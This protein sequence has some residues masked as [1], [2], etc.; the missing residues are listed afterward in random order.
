MTKNGT[1]SSHRHGLLAGL[2][3][4]VAA[5][6]TARAAPASAEG[7]YAINQK[8]SSVQRDAGD[9]SDL[10]NAYAGQHCGSPRGG[11]PQATPDGVGA[12]LGLYNVNTHQLTCAI[13]WTRGTGAHVVWGDVYDRF[14]RDGYERAYGYPIVD[15]T[16]EPPDSHISQIF[17]TLGRDG[18]AA[19]ERYTTMVSSTLGAYPLRGGF[20]DAW[21]GSRGQIGAPMG[22]AQPNVATHVCHPGLLRGCTSGE[23]GTTKFDGYQAFQRW[24]A[25]AQRH[26]VTCVC[27]AAGN[28]PTTVLA[29]F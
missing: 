10:S 21:W 22:D 2:L 4:L 5:T 9:A 11:T 19:P 23:Q 27:I 17:S 1:R 28:P 18:R 15:T 6:S 20:A 8:L 24:D 12:Y 3:A 29:R 7:T 13:Y 14:A 25:S 26:Q 16:I